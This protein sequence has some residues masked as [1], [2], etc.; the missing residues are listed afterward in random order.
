MNYRDANLPPEER[1]QDL[2]SRMTLE[3]KVNQ[4]TQLPAWTAY[5]KTATGIETGDTGR[6]E[7]RGAPGSSNELASRNRAVDKPTVKPPA[8]DFWPVS[9]A[10]WSELVVD[11]IIPFTFSWVLLV[12]FEIFV[13]KS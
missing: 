3:E 13:E 11:T 9:K 7:T 12:V 10:D 8:A 1:A 5:Q 4:L 2:L 6:S